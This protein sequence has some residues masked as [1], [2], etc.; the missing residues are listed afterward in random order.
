MESDWK[1]NKQS[2]APTDINWDQY[3]QGD[4]Q[5]QNTLLAFI[6]RI[7]LI[8]VFGVVLTPLTF[9]GEAS[10]LRRFIEK[11]LGRDTKMYQVMVDQIAPFILMLF[12]Y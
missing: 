7:I 2:P 4:Q 1:L 12:N 9:I 10:Y 5:I 11:V 6:L 8:L 3:C